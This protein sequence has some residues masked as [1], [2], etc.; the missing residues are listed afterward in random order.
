MSGLASIPRSQQS[1]PAT[2]S[3]FLNFVLSFRDR[4]REGVE[5]ARV[6]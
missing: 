1:A 4:F 6:P 5:R 3:N 2:S